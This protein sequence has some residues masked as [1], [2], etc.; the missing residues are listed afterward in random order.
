MLSEEE[1][2]SKFLTE[3]TA[4]DPEIRASYLKHFEAEVEEFSDAMTRAFI[5]WRSLMPTQK[6]TTD[7][8]MFLLWCIRRSVS[9]FSR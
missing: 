2:R 6:K 1:I 8:R 5:N 7:T 4:D 3:L 9:T